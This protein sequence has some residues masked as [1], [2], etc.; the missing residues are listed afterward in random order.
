MEK[1]YI[2]AGPCSVESQQ[3]LQE[4]CREL[5]STPHVR[6]IRAGVW[7]P[8]TR[9]GGFEGLGEPALHW[10]KEIADSNMER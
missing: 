9:P 2:I 3:Q 8:R 1:P 5:C 10:M 4:V 6:M 7:K